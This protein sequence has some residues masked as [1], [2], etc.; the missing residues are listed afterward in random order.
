M[1]GLMLGFFASVH[2]ASSLG[3]INP[4]LQHDTVA[5]NDLIP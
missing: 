3:P 1:N 4:H 5:A 2:Q